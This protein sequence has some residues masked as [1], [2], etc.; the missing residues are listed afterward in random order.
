LAAPERY[1]VDPARTKT[2][3]VQLALAGAIGGPLRWRQWYDEGGDPTAWY[4]RPLT[5][6]GLCRLLG[7]SAA[8]D[9]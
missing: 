4:G 5:A 1:L 7:W 2:G 6:E 9:E 3:R 8:N